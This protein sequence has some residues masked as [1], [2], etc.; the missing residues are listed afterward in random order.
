MSGI[1]FIE[2]DCILSKNSN[3]INVN[4]YAYLNP[5]ANNPLKGMAIDYIHSLNIV[6]FDDYEY[7]NY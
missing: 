7:D 2:D 4:A 3:S 5:N 1:I 6:D